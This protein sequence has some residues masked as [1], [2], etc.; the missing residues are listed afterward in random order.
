MVTIADLDAKSKE[1]LVSIAEAAGLDANGQLASRP[2][3][4]VLTR[5]CNSLQTSRGFPRW[6]SWRPC[7]KDTV[8]CVRRPSVPPRE[9][10]TYPSPRYA[11]SP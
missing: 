1:E 2:R 9:T 8:S 6:A 3:D 10:S 11:A 5:C 4:E 7:P